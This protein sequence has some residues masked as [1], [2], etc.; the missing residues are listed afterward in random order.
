VYVANSGSNTVAIIDTKTNTVAKI[1]PVGNRPWDVIANPITNTIYVANSGS[2]DIHVIDGIN[3][4]I[5]VGITF[6]INPEGSGEIYCND[7]K[8]SNNDYVNYVINTS[9]KCGAIAKTHNESLTGY[10]P[11]DKILYPIY[12]FI[13]SE[14]SQ[15]SDFKFKDWSGNLISIDSNS[16]TFSPSRYGTLTANF[17]QIPPPL[18]TSDLVAIFSVL[19]GII[20]T[21][22]GALFYK[23]KDWLY[24]RGKRY[25]NRYTKRIKA[26]YNLSNQNPTE[27]LQLLE[28]I[29]KQILDLVV[30]GKISKS[31]YD[32][33][34]NTISQYQKR[35]DKSD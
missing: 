13:S 7:R 6:N 19:L 2:N 31:H 26:V 18:S 35:V 14:M 30:N 32:I 16:I 5:I 34:I 20:I 3:N 23:N 25:L 28:E 8:I 21:S 1:V 33:L 12:H 10:I 4:N 22:I 9:L 27:C 24:R 17:I 29:R 11:I 15:S